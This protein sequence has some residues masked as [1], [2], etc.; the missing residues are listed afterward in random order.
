M[1]ILDFTLFEMVHIY[2]YSI[3]R[4]APMSA[5]GELGFGV[6]RSVLGSTFVQH[7]RCHR[8]GKSLAR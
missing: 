3:C 1:I 4:R 8:H 6:Q 2:V 7:S 5:V